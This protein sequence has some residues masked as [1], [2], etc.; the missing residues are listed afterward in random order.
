MCS[1][2]RTI[3]LQ[4]FKRVV[5][6]YLQNEA[7]INSILNNINYET[8][9]RLKKIF[10]DEF[11]PDEMEGAAYIIVFTATVLW[12]KT[13]LLDTDNATEMLLANVV[14]LTRF[15]YIFGKDDENGSEIK[16]DPSFYGRFVNAVSND[17]FTY[18]D[19]IYALKDYIESK[20]FFDILMGNILN[21]GSDIMREMLDFID[22]EAID[23]TVKRMDGLFWGGGS[24][25][26][27]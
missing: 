25:G 7:G 21:G 22:F 18:Y 10:E 17:F 26:L 4:V 20:R 6:A 2:M 27:N 16:I 19:L 11:K 23:N 15:F 9:E 13:V 24:F 14:L 12:F 1:G 3:D 5:D 8:A